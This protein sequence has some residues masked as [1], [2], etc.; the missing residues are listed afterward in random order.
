MKKYDKAKDKQIKKEFV[1]R[2]GWMMENVSEVRDIKVLES[3]MID[4]HFLYE[5][6]DAQ[7]CEKQAVDKLIYGD[8]DVGPG[9]GFKGNPD[10]LPI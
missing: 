9:P 5:E 8:K 3:M 4:A 7:L 1:K 6:I 10:E 2:I